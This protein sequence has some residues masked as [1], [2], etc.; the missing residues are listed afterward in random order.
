M[1]TEIDHRLAAHLRMQPGADSC[2][3][4]GADA[5]MTDIQITDVLVVGAGPVGLSLTSDLTRRGITCRV[6][7]QTP[8]YHHWTRA[9]GM[10]AR[11]VAL[12]DNLRVFAALLA[13]PEPRHP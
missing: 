12:F 6:I 1:H 8:T 5:L 4:K 3:P 9:R 10:S 11:T 7:D 2:K 13:Q